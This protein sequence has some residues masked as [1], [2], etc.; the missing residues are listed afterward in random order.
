MITFLTVLG[1]IAAY[2]VPALVITRAK[3][4]REYRAYLSW[5]NEGGKYN[6]FYKEAEW[7]PPSVRN[8]SE[9]TYKAYRNSVAT[10]SPPGLAGAIWPLYLPVVA[11]VK[12][13]HPEVKAPDYH[14]IQELEKLKL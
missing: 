13:V 5:R 9:A 6:H 12:F 14:R 1:S 11:V 3:Y 4:I 7:R 10:T 8:R 2:L